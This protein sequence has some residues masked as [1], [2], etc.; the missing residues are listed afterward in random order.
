MKLTVVQYSLSILKLVVYVE[1]SANI[2]ITYYVHLNDSCMFNVTF[3]T[4]VTMIMVV[5]IL[6]TLVA[7][8]TNL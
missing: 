7:I 1:K 5:T 2:N 3:V 4:T 8:V 6:V